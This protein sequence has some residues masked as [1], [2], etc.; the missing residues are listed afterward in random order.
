MSIGVHFLG[1]SM[2]SPIIAASGTFGFGLECKDYLDLNEVGAISCKGL[3]LTPWSGNDGVRIAE[4]PSG[5]LN[6]IGL[7]NPGVDVFKE[8]YLPELKKYQVPVI[9]NV[10]GKDIEEYG[11]VAK[12]L[13][14]EGVRALE[15]NISCPNVKNGGISFGTDPQMAAEVTREVK[16]NTHLPVIMKLSPNVTDIVT[17]AKAV[18]ESGADAIS[19]INTLLGM[20]IDIRTRKPILGNITGG[21]SGPAI[22]PVALRMV[23]QVS[24]AVHIPICGMGG[25]MSSDDVIEFMLAGAHTV[26]VGTASLIDPGAIET[27]TED[28]K[29]WCK[30]NRVE[31]ISDI[32]GTLQA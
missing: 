16:R 28:L 1:I 10:V 18:E 13:S 26:Q 31:K 19:L 9:C 29:S 27:I 7:E 3:A 5:I 11:K 4:T 12:A 22:K 30:E 20:A 23:W 6:C 14:V 8:K 15:V 2:K 17:I 32:V 25:I 24:Q 21:L